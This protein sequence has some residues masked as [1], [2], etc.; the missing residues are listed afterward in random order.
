MIIDT[1]Y[2]AVDDIGHSILIRHINIYFAI[3][4]DATL[5]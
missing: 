2:Y 3:D 4:A 1:Y 5:H